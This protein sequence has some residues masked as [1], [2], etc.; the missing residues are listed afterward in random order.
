MPIARDHVLVDA[1][2]AIIVGMAFEL[3]GEHQPVDVLG[4]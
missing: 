1:D 3:A 4:P 2:Y